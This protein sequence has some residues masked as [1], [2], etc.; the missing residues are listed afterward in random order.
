[1]SDILCKLAFDI[2]LDWEVLVVNTVSGLK[3]LMNG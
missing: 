1:M 2:E 3:E